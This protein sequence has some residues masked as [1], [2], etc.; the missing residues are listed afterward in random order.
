MNNPQIFNARSLSIYGGLLLCLILAALI[1]GQHPTSV[2]QPEPAMITWKLPTLQPTSTKPNLLALR[3]EDG[4]TLMTILKQ[5]NI[6]NDD[7][8]DVISTISASYDL[9]KLHI[10]Q[11]VTLTFDI[12]S[13]SSHITAGSNLR[14]ESLKLRIS[15]EKEITAH[16]LANNSFSLTEALTPIERHVIRKHGVI[17]SSLMATVDEMGI[18]AA[19][20]G[21]II[22]AY[23]Y[24]VDFQRDIQPGD[25]FDIVFE[26][27]YTEDGQLARKGDVIFS[28]LTL[29]GKR[30]NIYKH[31][32]IAGQT[33]YFNDEGY[34]V[35]KELLRTP[36]NAAHISS[37]FGMRMH[38][39]LGYSTM[40]KG[41]DFA[42][43]TGTPIFAAGNGVIEEIGHK[44]SYGNYIRIRHNDT[45]STA[46]AHASRFAKGLRRG[47]R[48][49]QGD[50]IAYVGSTGRATGPHLH[51][52]VL[53]D[54]KQ[55]N[56][57]SIK[58]SPGLKLAGN[59]LARF[60]EYKKKLERVLVNNP[61]Q[62][63]LA[64]DNHNGLRPVN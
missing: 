36:L 46:Y 4:D 34:S 29:S 10:G 47:D 14:L 62:T 45:F 6:N 44:G 35:R 18:P 13:D 30:F 31:T 1:Y 53:I 49:E 63:E 17:S 40:H 3:V 15:P 7:A 19:I 42:A 33:D 20:M 56:P 39:I 16:R 41:I 55:V 50:V 9:T 38:P 37:G 58:V 51:Y 61:N 26:N 24:D 12:P 8:I 25:Q 2:Q 57:L 64:F 48:V 11:N 5:A 54:N 21:D 28:S 52:E 59:E 60:T 22:K 32:T 43:T 23:S 27:Y